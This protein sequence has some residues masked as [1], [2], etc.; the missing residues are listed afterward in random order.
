MG[1]PS[2]PAPAQ[3]PVVAVHGL[4]E[5]GVE[6]VPDGAGGGDGATAH[7]ASAGSLCRDELAGRPA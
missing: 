3:G 7:G 4:G 5:G 2:T 1:T 6:Q